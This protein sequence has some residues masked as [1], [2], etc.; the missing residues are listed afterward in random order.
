MKRKNEELRVN[1]VREDS[2][3]SLTGLKD[4]PIV[5]ISFAKDKSI[6]IL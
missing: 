1:S 6:E 5:S 3:L 4:I 2:T